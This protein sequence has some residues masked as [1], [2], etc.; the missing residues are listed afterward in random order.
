MKAIRSIA[1]MALVTLSVACGSSG[2]GTS[3]V[4]QVIPGR[5]ALSVSVIPNPIVARKVSGNTY[6]FPFTVS[7]R[8]SNGVAVNI[9]RVSADVRALGGIPVYNESYSTAE[10]ARMNYPTQIAGNSELRYSLNPRKEVPDDRLFGGVSAVITVDGTD[11]NGN[12]VSADTTV[13]VTR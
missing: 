1:S 13:T 7:V 11:A 6:D 10:I 5:A 3:S 2:G 8:E 12:Q 4:P 9:N